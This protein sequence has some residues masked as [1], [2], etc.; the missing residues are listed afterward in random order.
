MESGWPAGMYDGAVTDDSDYQFII[1][2]AGAGGAEA[3]L[4]AARR[5]AKGVLLIEK[6]RLGGGALHAGAIPMRSLMGRVRAMRQLI[7]DCSSEGEAPAS[8]PDWINLQRRTIARLT[9]HLREELRATGV[10]MVRGEATLLGEGRIHIAQKKRHHSRP[11]RVAR[12]AHIILATGSKPGGSEQFWPESAVGSSLRFISLAEAPF[13]LVIIGG[14]HIG[15]EFACVYNALGA[16]VTLVEKGGRLLPEM[17]R[18][19]GEYLRKEFE[20]GGIRVRLGDAARAVW[21]NISGEFAVAGLE[22]GNEQ[23]A[24]EKILVAT[25]RIP[26][27]NGLGLEA[28]GVRFQPKRGILVDPFLQTTAPGIYAIGDVNGLCTLADSA[29]AQ[30]Q[31]AVENALGE[32]HSFR[33]EETPR[34]VHT[35]PPISAIGVLEDEAVAAG[36]TAAVASV[37]FRSMNGLRGASEPGMLKLIADAETRQLLGGMIIGDQAPDWIGKLG[38]LVRARADAL[39]L[40]SEPEDPEGFTAALR[41]C[42]RQI[43]A[44]GL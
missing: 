10:E 7:S 42:G 3:A 34:H 33:R 39:H 14:G 17:D 19:A 23:M 9:S 11:E 25:G 18:E 21:G 13:R 6:D 27:V 20:H 43:F 30:A 5:G 15:C 38:A 29:R 44:Q 41:D 26:N 2:G 24:A 35:D 22:V 4:F 36:R 12:A 37:R 40:A 8:L 32:R 16:D 1:V 31:I 28:A